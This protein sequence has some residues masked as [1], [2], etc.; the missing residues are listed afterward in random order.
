MDNNMISIDELMKRRLEGGEE[1]D[2]SGAWLQMKDLLDKEI[3]RDKPVGL[4][5]W[6]RLFTYTGALLLLCALSLGGYEISS[7]VRD[8]KGGN[9][10]AATNNTGTTTANNNSVTTQVSSNNKAAEGNTN[11]G[12]DANATAGMVQNSTDVNSIDNS[13]AAHTTRDNNNTDH[14]AVA[15][16]T[17]HKKTGTAHHHQHTVSL[18][19]AV[20]NTA[21]SNTAATAPSSSSTT[22]ADK[23]T[24]D[25]SIAA[26][27]TQNNGKQTAGASNAS[28]NKSDARSAATTSANSDVNNT[29]ATKE[30]GSKKHKGHHTTKIASA[31]DQSSLAGTTNTP[32]TKSSPSTTVAANDNSAT[33]NSANSNSDNGSTA[34][35]KNNRSA[36]SASNAGTKQ[37]AATDK[38]VAAVATNHKGAKKK[39]DTKHMEQMALAGTTAMPSSLP[40]ASAGSTVS[41][42]ATSNT[43]AANGNNGIV[44]GG[45]NGADISNTVQTTVNA[46]STNDNHKTNKKQK[47]H[48][49]TYTAKTNGNTTTNGNGKQTTDS[50]VANN[51]TKPAPAVTGSAMAAG[52][53]VPPA[54][55]K[56]K[57]I[58]MEN[59]YVKISTNYGYYKLDT[60]AIEDVD[61]PEDY[62]EMVRAS[63]RKNKTSPVAS[64][65]AGSL[66]EKEEN[67]TVAV[68]NPNAAANILAKS[69]TEKLAATTD[70][71]KGQSGSAVESITKLFN[72][73]KY[74]VQGVHMQAGLT[75]GINATFFGPSGTKG[76]DFGVQCD[77]VFNETWSLLAQIKYFNRISSNGAFNNN[78]STYAQ[79]SNGTYVKDS[80]SQSIGYTTLHSFELPLAIEYS[81]EKFIFSAG[82]NLAYNLAVNVNEAPQQVTPL[83]A[84]ATSTMGIET[85]PKLKVSDFNSKFGLGYLLGIGFRVSP[86]V[87]LD[88]RNVQT[89]WDN[90]K[91][92][93]AKA[94]SSQLYKNPSFQLSFGYTFGSKKETEK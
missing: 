94:I 81:K 51:T 12:T 28:S 46:M 31:A 17:E 72:D 32:S 73:I 47:G 8:L 26:N 48:S 56:T 45:L 93:G 68:I 60:V 82:L 3:P 16:N 40:G 50:K 33:T 57:L 80:V 41:M 58:R 66:A 88:F 86:Q 74:N 19:D 4:L 85:S 69:Y 7:S 65:E 27:N 43:T 39:H 20:S 89:F 9:G 67:S 70:Y 29:V 11:N 78:Y 15:S 49:K 25:N 71:K 62:R 75:G 21:L 44:N 13:T 14:A 64:A 59:H 23:N 61:V 79:Q 34:G 2:R 84:T 30:H 37:N 91:T 6:R 92:G 63:S 36:N 90:S 1:Q 54:R 76:F 83:S 38:A 77:M 5:F 55:L 22:N 24:N 35:T 53:D 42:P 18:P 52:A 10:I 87:T